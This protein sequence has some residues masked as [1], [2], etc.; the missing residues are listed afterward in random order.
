M[1][2]LRL[3][4]LHYTT[5]NTDDYLRQINRYATWG[6]MNLRDESAAKAQ[7]WP[8]LLRAP[9]RFFQLYVLR[10]GFLDGIPGLQICT[11]TAFYSFLKQ[12]KLWEIQH[13]IPQPDPETETEPAGE[14]LDFNAAARSRRE[15]DQERQRRAA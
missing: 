4:L 11:F 9:L 8:M 10:L 5:W 3:P 2:K 12:A 7:F 1:G 13:A 14:T 15:A 6:A